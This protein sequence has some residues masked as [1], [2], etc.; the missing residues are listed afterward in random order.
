ME[1]DINLSK[2]QKKQKM[3]HLKKMGV[4]MAKMPKDEILKHKLPNDLL[5]AFEDYRNITKY[6]AKKR[7]EQYI[8]KLMR[9]LYYDSKFHEEFNLLLSKIN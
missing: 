1:E 6:G 3:I 9:K 2:T 8:G 7:Q 4:K 5:N